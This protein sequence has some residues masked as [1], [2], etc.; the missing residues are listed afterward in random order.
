METFQPKKNINA[1]GKRVISVYV[2]G[3]MLS[4]I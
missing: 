2:T 1:M 4:P 3:F